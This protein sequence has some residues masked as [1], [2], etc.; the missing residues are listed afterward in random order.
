MIERIGTLGFMK[1]S[2]NREPDENGDGPEKHGQC[3]D[4][5]LPHLQAAHPFTEAARETGN[6]VHRAVNGSLIHRAGKPAGQPH[7]GNHNRRVIQFIHTVFV[8][9]QRA[10]P[11]QRLPAHAW[12]SSC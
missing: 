8:F 11:A 3:V 9:D 6:T 5:D 7:E 2:L 1:A 12:A 10:E 4:A